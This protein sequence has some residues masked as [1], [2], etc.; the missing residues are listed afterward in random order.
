MKGKSGGYRVITKENSILLVYIYSK[1]D[2]ENVSDSK[3]D[4]IIKNYNI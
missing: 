2:T 3:I 4:N 1:S